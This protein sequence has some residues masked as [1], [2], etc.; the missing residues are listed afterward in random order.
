MSCCPHFQQLIVSCNVFSLVFVLSKEWARKAREG[1]AKKGHKLCLLLVLLFSCFFLNVLLFL[2]FAIWF[3]VWTLFSSTYFTADAFGSLFSQAFRGPFQMC[4][5]VGV[6]LSFAVVRRSFKL[7][8]LS[9]FHCFN[10]TDSCYFFFLY[11]LSCSHFALHPHC[12]QGH[13]FSGLW[14]SDNAPFVFFWSFA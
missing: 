4:M 12:D 3:I 11:G 2:F 14:L 10:E 6:P 7:L 1:L 13:P 9:R 5:Y 8:A